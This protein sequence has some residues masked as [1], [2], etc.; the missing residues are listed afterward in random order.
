VS[1]IGM[2]VGEHSSGGTAA[3]LANTGSGSGNNSNSGAITVVDTG[4]IR[5]DVQVDEAD[6][7]NIAVGQ[8]ATVAFDALANRRYTG[9]VIALAP[10]GTTS[11]G[12]VGYQV[13]I[14][15]DRAAGPGAGRAAG[16][17]PGNAERAQQRARPADGDAP[18]EGQGAGDPIREVR[19]GMTAT[20]TITYAQRDDVL[21]VPN[22]AI[23][24]QGRDRVVQ[25][26]TANGGESRKVQIGMANDQV[27]EITDGLQEGDEVIIPT[28]S[29]RA[30]IPGA[31]QG[32]APGGGATFGGPA[33]V[34]R[35][36]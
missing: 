2:A 31:R 19:P 3:P 17:R 16:A 30:A 7:A 13:S 35:T 4:K 12:V 10:S 28:T 34:V 26:A 21:H 29:T 6:I 36:R 8:P 25:V 24:R 5:V 27:T 14:A 1:A 15:L 20:A 11:Q 18:A 22:R 9:Q 23:T 33:P 32:A